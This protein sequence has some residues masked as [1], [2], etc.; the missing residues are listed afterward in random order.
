MAKLFTPRPAPGELIRSDWMNQLADAVEQAHDTIVALTQ[1][2]TTLEQLV[3]A[4]RPPADLKVEWD[5][6]KLDLVLKKV[7]DKKAEI[8]DARELVNYAYKELYANKDAL[9]KLRQPGDP[10]PEEVLL[11][12]K[13]AGISSFDTI[14]AID[15]RAPDLAL[16]MR[17][18]LTSAGKN[19]LS[20]DADA[21]LLSF[22]NL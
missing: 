3:K 7:K 21:G 22:G 2:V 5:H 13:E 18:T 15:Q 8:K 6:D 11:F 1:R 4:P 16:G 19:P 14:A 10:R 17:D 12:M 20:F 9:I